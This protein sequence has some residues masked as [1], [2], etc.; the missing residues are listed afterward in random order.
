M[1]ASQPP[2]A[3][4]QTNTPK[5]SYLTTHMDRL[6]RRGLYLEYFTV[7]Y[8]LI[9][10]FASLLFG[11]MAESIALVGF[12]LDSIVESLSGVILI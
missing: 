5:A 3:P 6:Y 7:G 11:L 2:G 1:T 10:A 12:G 9:E 4:L 8:N